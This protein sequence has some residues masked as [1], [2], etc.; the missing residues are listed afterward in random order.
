MVAVSTAGG[1][2]SAASA[3]AT[4]PRRFADG[5]VH[6]LRNFGLNPGRGN[7]AEH[8][9]D[10]DGG[11]DQKDQVRKRKADA[12]GVFFVTLSFFVVRAG[13]R[14]EHASGRRRKT[15][16]RLAG[17]SRVGRSS[18][19]AARLTAASTVSARRCKARL[20]ASENALGCGEKASRM[21]M[22]FSPTRTGAA[23]MERMPRARQVSASTR[24]SSVGVVA[25]QQ[26]SG[27]HALAGKSGADLQARADRR[28]AGAGTGA[29]VHEIRVGGGERD[30]RS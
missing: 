8:K 7:D 25:A 4:T 28:S 16:D 5:C 19:R 17:G 3:P 23:R 20:S 30:G 14:K 13:G 1:K 24:E 2:Q 27:L 11:A 21:P 12:A 10:R 18:A 22:D 26:A 6:V 15:G 9:R 29:A